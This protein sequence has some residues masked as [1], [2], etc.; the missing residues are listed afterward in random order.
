M[1]IVLETNFFKYFIVMRNR[2]RKN[3]L[4][5]LLKEKNENCQSFLFYKEIREKIN[6][7]SFQKIENL[8]FLKFMKNKK[9]FETEELRNDYFFF[10][11][12][13]L[14]LEKNKKNDS[15]IKNAKIY[16]ENFLV[17][18]EEEMNKLL[19]F[20]LK[21]KIFILKDIIKKKTRKS[22]KNNLMAKLGQKI[23]K[24]ENKG[25]IKKMR[26]SITKN[27]DGFLIQFQNLQQDQNLLKNENKELLQNEKFFE[28]NNLDNNKNFEKI[29]K[30]KDLLKL[31]KERKIKMDCFFYRFV[32]EK[33][34]EFLLSIFGKEK[35]VFFYLQDKLKRRKRTLDEVDFNDLMI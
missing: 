6:D 22:L 10:L 2:R 28:K 1:I 16:I 32:M 26:N 34:C 23:E 24:T 30:E 15:I 27:Q 17:Y 18:N 31:F 29:L 13:F 9:I 12:N 21:Q 25:M 35:F 7:C 3:K 20:F 8:N 33:I 4:I 14:K 5:I 11:F 19:I